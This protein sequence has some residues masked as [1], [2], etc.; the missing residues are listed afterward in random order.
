MKNFFEGG[1]IMTLYE[2]RINKI[3][4][5][6]KY[7]N[8][9]RII[10]FG[11][12]DGKLVRYLNQSNAFKELACVEISKKQI[13]KLIK[14]F[15]GNN[16]IKIFD[17]SFFE[18]NELFKKYDATILSEVIEHLT[19][20]EIDTLL[21]LILNTYCPQILIITTPNKSF[22]INLPTLHNGLRHSSHL[23]EFTI[24]DVE[25]FLEQIQGKFP[26]YTAYRGYCDKNQSTHFIIIEKR[27]NDEQS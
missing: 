10:D 9:K 18:Y 23:F 6:L 14:N 20:S 8:A 3:F 12:G 13:T 15:G 4:D 25:G 21:N 5:L 27:K 7:Y 16:K 22:N 11:C 26:L 17:Q 1:R 2:C 19:N 24:E